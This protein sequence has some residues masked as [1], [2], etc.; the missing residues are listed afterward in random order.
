MET[1]NLLSL[2]S[3]TVPNLV[4]FTILVFVFLRAQSNLSREFTAYLKSRDE[5]NIRVIRENT[6]VIRENTKILAVVED[7]ISN[8]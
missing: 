8:G 6:E 7:I 4:V 1:T 2:L 3:E 5:E